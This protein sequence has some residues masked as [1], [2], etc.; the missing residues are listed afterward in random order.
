MTTMV[1]ISNCPTLFVLSQCKKLA[2]NWIWCSWTKF[3]DKG[4]A[5]KSGSIGFLCWL[6]TRLLASAKDIFRA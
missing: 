5:I 3:T 1:T 4:V 6:N 2:S